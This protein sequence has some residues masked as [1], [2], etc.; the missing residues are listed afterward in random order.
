GANYKALVCIFLAGGNDGNNTVIP[1]HSDAT[2]SNYAAYSA[3]RSTQGLAIAQASLLPITVPRISN[4][5]YGLHPNF[6]PITGGINNGIY[7]LWAQGKLG[8]V[9]NVGTLV[10]PMTKTQYQNGS[11]TKPYQ[12][13]SHSDQVAQAQAG[14]AGTQSFTGWGGRTSDKMTQANNPS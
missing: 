10:R 6:G 2:I 11:V 3:A 13:F 14:F 12:L 1:N 8:V 4:L 7:E 9:T 5:T